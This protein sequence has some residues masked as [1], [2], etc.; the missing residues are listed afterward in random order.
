[1]NGSC[2]R[3]GAKYLDD[4]GWYFKYEKCRFSSN[5]FGKTLF[6]KC[7]SLQVLDMIWVELELIVDYLRYMPTVGAKR[8]NYLEI[9]IGENASDTF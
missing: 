9:T 3:N 7:R 4:L 5:G 1:M 2:A 8:T 6:E